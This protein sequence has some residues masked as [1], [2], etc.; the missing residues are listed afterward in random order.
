MQRGMS[1]YFL[2]GF[3][4]VTAFLGAMNQFIIASSACIWYFSPRSAENASDK[5]VK[6]AV[7]RSVY[8]CLCYHLGTLAFGSFLLAVVQM[9]RLVL[10]YMTAQL[11][12]A[13]QQSKIVI[14]LLACLSCFMACFERFIKFIN[15]L[16]YIQC[17]ITSYNFCHSCREAFFLILRNTFLFA[18][19]SGIGEVFIW[20]GRI[21]I[22][23]ATTAICW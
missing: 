20:F 15:K 18:I 3:L 21:F 7:T 6:A 1:Y 16:A 9:I 13:N 12:K 17:A 5:N 4:W 10:A 2:F 8:R 19:A 23:L 14:K 11:K 22:M